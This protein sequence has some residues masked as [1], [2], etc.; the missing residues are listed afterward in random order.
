MLRPSASR[1][2]NGNPPLPA[3]V[4]R[5]SFAQHGATMFFPHF[6][7]NA[8]SRERPDKLGGAGHCGNGGSAGA[9]LRAGAA[10]GCGG[11]GIFIS[12]SMTADCSLAISRAVWS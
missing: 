6:V 9:G 5:R 4:V 8:G 2:S 12:I 11:S 7:S 10:G 3:A 1:D